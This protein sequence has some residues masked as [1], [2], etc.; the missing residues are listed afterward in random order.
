VIDSIKGRTRPVSIAQV[1][2]FSLL[3]EVQRE[4]KVK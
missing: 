3:E 1:V 2:N 4:M